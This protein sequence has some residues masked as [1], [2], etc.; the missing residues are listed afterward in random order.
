MACW[1]LLIKRSWILGAPCNVTHFFQAFSS[2]NKFQ[3]IDKIEH[4]KREGSITTLKTSICIA[5]V[6]LGAFLY[7]AQH[8]SHWSSS[9]GL[10]GTAQPNELLMKMYG[11]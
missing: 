1:M 2:E 8:L 10:H 3:I 6:V 5:V 4:G 9:D 11:T 7:Q